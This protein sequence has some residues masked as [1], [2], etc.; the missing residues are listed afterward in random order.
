M[1]KHL[2]YANLKKNWKNHLIIILFI[3]LSVSVMQSVGLTCLNLFQSINALYVQADPPHFLQ[4]HKGEID[5]QAIDSFNQSFDGLKDAQTIQMINASGS[6]FL[7]ISQDSRQAPLSLENFKLDISMVKQADHFDFLLNQDKEKIHLQPGQIALPRLLLEEYD[8]KIGD[9]IRYHTG[10]FTQ[11]YQVA[12][13]MYDAQMNTSMAGSVRF[14]LDDRDHQTLIDQQVET[15]YM[16]EATFLDPGLANRY[17]VAYEQ[18]GLPINGQAVTYAMILT[19]SAFSDI[20][21]AFIILITGFIFLVISYISLRYIILME[22]E[23]DRLVIGNLKAIGVPYR[24]IRDLYLTKF[25]W[26][27]VLGIGLGSIFAL[28]FTHL[29]TG[30]IERI[31]GR[32]NLGVWG[33]ILGVVIALLMYLLIIVFIRTTLSKIRQ[34]T[35]IDLLVANKSFANIAKVKRAKRISKLP[36]GL[37]L[38]FNQSRKGYAMITWLTLATT[39]AL[40]FPYRLTTL[41]AGDG[42]LNYM[43]REDYPAFVEVL[44]DK[45]QEAVEEEL[46]KVLLAHVDQVKMI[47]SKVYRQKIT[48]ADKKSDQVISTHIE[49]GQDLGQ[50]LDYLSGRAP[51]NNQKE[52]ALSYLIAQDLD[53]KVGDSIQVMR[54]NQREAFELVGIYQDIT[55]GG[56]TG[57]TNANFVGDDLQ[58]LIINLDDFSDQELQAIEQDLQDSAILNHRYKIYQ[59]DE[60]VG[61]IFG[62]VTGQIRQAALL[63]GMIALAILL[64]LV[65]LFE[66]LRVIKDKEGFICKQHLGI[67]NQAIRKEEMLAVLTAGSKGLVMALI[68]VT[69]F[70]STIMTAFLSLLNLGIN[71]ITTSPA[72]GDL[73][74]ILLIVIVL[75][76]ATL[77]GAQ[78]IKNLRLRG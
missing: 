18:A 67:S 31:F 53:L 7:V 15:E 1:N 20:L 62:P 17:Q 57:K 45:D 30:R 8:I 19:I 78:S 75:L 63:V 43:G 74:A 60:L 72:I 38:G 2:R 77:I 69:F 36:L 70:A 14:L 35:V 58:K 66:K 50:N 11:D 61:Q 76:V 46:S 51:A 32:S 42:F 3:A 23:E 27:T 59:R 5:Q 22:I 39:L 28:G 54:Q 55:S 73:V 24:G 52:L 26:L 16:I 13:I 41:F 10:R 40:I 49:V 12:A 34:F 64:V 21:N 25:R 56:K 6:E 71:Q 9:T 29:L 48:M 4:L 33:I 47:K 65:I 68:I 37:A 44:P